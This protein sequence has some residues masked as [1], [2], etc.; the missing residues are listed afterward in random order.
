M[1]KIFSLLFLL[2]IF[3]PVFSEQDTAI[4]DS[5]NK[6][7]SSV[8]SSSDSSTQNDISFNILKDDDDD[9]DDPEVS[10]WKI[11]NIWKR[12]SCTFNEGLSFALVNRIQKQK[13]R[14]NFVWEDRM[15]GGY[16][17]VQV[18]N[19]FSFEVIARTQL[20]YPFFHTFN[21]QEVF[22]KQT[23]LY[24]F[25]EF[26]GRPFKYNHYRYITFNAIPGVHL[27]YQLTDEYHLLYLGL[28]LIGG[29]ELPITSKWTVLLD[30]TFI[31]D[32]PNLGSNSLMQ[33]YDYSW[34]YQFSCGIRYSKIKR[35]K[36]RF[37]KR[38]RK[39]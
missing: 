1:K 32:Y 25:D 10:E 3:S 16:F 4:S 17:T 38:R 11:I 2:T 27:M 33:P 39:N 21:E 22:A 23:I 7:E 34:Q 36:F 18:E 35:N 6:T 30:G 28:G 37:I 20:F 12:I 9:Y 19:L 5:E 26:V 8:E 31:I 13:E 29:I 15:I 14:S 24:A